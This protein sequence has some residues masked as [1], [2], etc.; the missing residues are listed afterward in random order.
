MARRTWSMQ[1]AKTRFREIVA[2]AR[3]E[4]Q[5]VTEHGK[6]AVVI[7]AA[8]EYERLR[9]L[10]H[11]RLPSFAE[12]LLGMPQGCVEFERIEARMRDPEF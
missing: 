10:R 8:D 5:T 12:L 9:K 7:I 3:R 4:P 6:P 2:A 1:D 11:L